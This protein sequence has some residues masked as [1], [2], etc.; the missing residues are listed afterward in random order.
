MVAWHLMIVWNALL[1]VIC[2]IDSDSLAENTGEV[3]LCAITYQKVNF[4]IV[5]P[6]LSI[7]FNFVHF[8][9]PFTFTVSSFIFLYSSVHCNSIFSRVF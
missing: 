8:C 3:C 4:M 1:C 2:Y 6:H 5:E 9:M 7:I